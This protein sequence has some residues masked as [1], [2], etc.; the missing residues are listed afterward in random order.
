MSSAELLGRKDEFSAVERLFSDV[1]GAHGP[2]ILILEGEAGIGKTSVWLSGLRR[3]RELGF[4]VLRCR[5]SPNETPLA[6]SAL[7]DVLRELTEEFLPQLP[8]PQ[9]NALEVSLLL[10]ESG[11]GAPDQRAVSLAA[12]NL[13]RTALEETPLLIAIDDVQWLDA[14]S[15][16]VLAFVFRRIEHDRCRVLLAR[17]IEDGAATEFPLDLEYAPRLLGTLERCT[18]GPLGP[19]AIQSLIRDRFST[20]LPR[21]TLVAICEASGGNPF[22]ALELAHTQIERGTLEPG[23]PLQVPESLGALVRNRLCA[24]PATTQEALLIAAALFEPTVGQV[25]KAGGGGLTRAIEDGV[26]EIEDTR[27]RFTHPLHASVIYLETTPEQRR[28]LHCRLIEVAISA[29]ER[30]RHLALGSDEPNE[31]VAA[32]LDRAALQATARGAPEAAAEFYEHAARFTPPEQIDEIRRRR[33]QTAENYYVAGDL[34][35]ARAL[36]RVILADFPEGSWRADVL[37]LLSDL[38][39]DLREGAELCRQAVEAAQG[40]DRRLALANIRLGAAYARLADQ[41]A[42]L[43]AQRAALEH[44]QRSG[45]SR[46]IVEA[47]Q[48]VVNATVLG[49]GTIDMEAMERAI[50]IENELGGL[51][52]RHSPRFWLG[53]QLH[54]TDELDRARPL[55]NAALD[56]AAHDGEVTDRLHILLPLIDLETRAGNWDIAERLI[57]DGLELA[58]DVGQEYTARYLRAFQLQLDV[59]R[60]EVEHVRPAVAELLAQAERSSDRPQVAHLLS[61]AGFV[62][63][64]VGDLEAAWQRLEPAVPLQS[65]LG[66]SW[67]C[68]SAI[69]YSNI[70]PNAIEALVALDQLK[71]A[72]RLLA[73]LEK[74]VDC[75]T[76][77]N[78]L[79]TSARSRALVAAARGDLKTAGEALADALEAL[80]S[81]PDPFERGRTML[82]LGTVE[83]RRKRKRNA[84]EALEQA[85]AIFDGLGARLWAEKAR[86]ELER[87]VGRRGGSLELTPTEFQIAELVAE[88]RSNKEIAAQLFLSVRTVETNL[89]NIYRRLGVESRTELAGRLTSSDSD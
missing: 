87:V 27:V 10:R 83:R 7:G 25:S 74:Q 39:E 81:L 21:Q 53:N 85:I 38:V 72:E 76:L 64:S 46:L 32:E 73:T 61:L 16:R 29:E 44:A 11:D 43:D 57:T 54:L 18:I 88:G 68:G 9:R 15:A 33:I 41:P 2:G 14:S 63:L 70:I 19:G 3:A 49:G 78:C 55:L 59:L 67:C 31:D 22:Y 40:D 36:A 77:P 47:L 13:L 50:A 51:P 65:N 89:S 80:E 79:A 71:T 58:F 26:I 20:H 45:D 28:Q 6:F 75:S 56:R 17:R 82:V 4:T 84:R 12:L 66:R 34:E 69:D 5:P 52:V 35:S 86:L 23:E 1:S 42:Q 62:E 24:L 37:V 60:G 8:P 48:G 30:A